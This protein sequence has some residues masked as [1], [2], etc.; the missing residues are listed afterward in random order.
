MGCA[1]SLKLYSA[2]KYFR[3]KCKKCYFG[4]KKFQKI[5]LLCYI[6]NNMYLALISFFVTSPLN[7]TGKTFS[8]SKL[9]DK[10]FSKKLGMIW[11]AYYE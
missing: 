9:P 7:K 6:E 2:I 11:N 10:T 1:I 3:I 4:E 5:S 8:P